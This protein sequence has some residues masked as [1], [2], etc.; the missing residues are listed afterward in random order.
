MTTKG[1]KGEGTRGTRLLEG[2]VLVRGKKG[3]KTATLR[4]CKLRAKVGSYSSRLDTGVRSVTSCSRA[5]GRMGL[6]ENGR[7]QGA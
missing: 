3:E 5:M 7:R 6:Q 4:E 2:M 1:R